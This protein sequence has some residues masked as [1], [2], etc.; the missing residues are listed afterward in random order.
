[1]ATMTEEDGAWSGLGV[2]A[3]FGHSAICD[4]DHD[5][6]IVFGGWDGPGRRNDVW[7]LSFGDAPIWRE[8]KTAGNLPCGR[9]SHTAIYDPVGHRMIVFGGTDGLRAFNDVWTLSLGDSPEWAELT[10]VGP[11]PAGREGQGAVYD[12]VRDRVVIFGGSDGAAVFDDAWALSLRGTPAWERLV[13]GGTLPGGLTGLSAVYDPVRDR[14]VVFGGRDSAWN[15]ASGVWALSLGDAPE[16]TELVPVGTGPLGRSGHSAVYDPRGDRMV[17]FGGQ[18][19]NAFLA[20]TWALTLQD[21]SVWTRLAPEGGVPCCLYLQAMVYDSLRRRVVMFGASDFDGVW[22]LSLEDPRAWTRLAPTSLPL[23]PRCGH[24][25]VRDARRNRMI[26]FGGRGPRYGAE[27]Y[28]DDVWVTSLEGALEWTQLTPIGA[29][30]DMSAYQSAIYDPV[31]DR[32][33]IYGGEFYRALDDLHAL[34]LSGA[35]AWTALTPSGTPPSPRWAHT[36]VYDPVRDRMLVFGGAGDCP[37]CYNDVWALSLGDAPA[38]TELAPIGTPPGARAA[39]TAI[40]D[41]VRD[42]MIVFGGIDGSD[43]F[44]EGSNDVW[45]LSL[46]SA[47]VWAALQPIGPAPG[48]RS[49]HTAIYDAARD[50]MVVFGGRR[51]EYGYAEYRD[52]WALSLGDAP[53]W[54]PILPAGTPPSRRESHT[55]IYDPLGDRMVVFGGRDSCGMFAL[56]DGGLLTWSSST[57]P[58]QLALVDAEAEPGR[59]KL[60]WYAASGGGLTATVYRRTSDQGWTALAEIAADGAGQLSY[61]DRSVMP[62]TRYG[63]RLGVFENDVEEYLGEAWVDVPAMTALALA[64]ARPNPATSELSVAFTLPDPASPARLEAFDLAGRR[65]AWRDVGPLGA[66]SHLVKLGEGADLGCGVYVI[67]LTRCER[68][69]TTRAVIVR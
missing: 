57:V 13:P 15:K 44:M 51:A 49:F 25:A 23:Y 7:A 30:P 45:A 55:A 40:Y 12:P 11:S 62:G 47:P 10:P 56:N 32:M 14:M 8:L 68:T 36:A 64:G 16:W 18:T 37:P 53:E 65:V 52:A 29:Q 17:V 48:V 5:R 6:M 19:N 1:M 24:S 35:P 2:G 26:V 69:L 46:A 50:R 66:G 58:V 54:T 39:H 22:A 4:R 28:L 61:E 27:Y 34:S 42:R 41:P 38:W 43:A 31:R 9:S 63:Y 33:V 3:R 21:T 67:R 20:D 60:T 59:V